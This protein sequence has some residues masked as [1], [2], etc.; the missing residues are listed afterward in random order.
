VRAAEAQTENQTPVP[1]EATVLFD[2]LA[3]TASVAIAVSGGSDSMGLLRLARAAGVKG[4][5]ALTVDHGLRQESASEAERVARWCAQVGVEHHV[6]T[7]AGEK[8]KTG[9]QAKARQARYDLMSN[10]CLVQGIPVL[11]TAHTQ[12]DQAETVAMRR[13]R[14]QSAAA[15]AGIWPE[16][17]WQGVRVVRPLLGVRRHA[18]RE[19]LT[20]LGQD[21]I[22]D[23]SNDDSRFERV[24][25]RRALADDKVVVLAAYA[26]QA[27]KEA[28]GLANAV[29]AWVAGHALQKP[30]GYFAFD[31]GL[32]RQEN[33]SVQAGV[34]ARL[35]SR[36]SGETS[37][38]ASALKRL[39][40]GL[41]IEGRRTLGEALI[42][43]RVGDVLVTRE[44]GRIAGNWV[45]IGPSGSV[46]WDRR[47]RVTAPAGSAVAPIGPC[48]LSAGQIAGRNA[49]FRA[50]CGAI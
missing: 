36:V 35:I 40:E 4:L 41:S 50:E 44:A 9:L 31:R 7:W 37:L 49:A 21:W 48:R 24:R 33:E 10:Y 2:G 14:T 16:T 12:D 39:S 20:Q 45:H 6:L 34:L 28:V 1:F 17:N 32:L 23:P 43:V 46:V 3:G 42:A 5:V 8:P 18:I 19:W 27:R 22:D 25:V 38:E 47:Y 29:D 11:M 30:E 15:L 26:E 13:V